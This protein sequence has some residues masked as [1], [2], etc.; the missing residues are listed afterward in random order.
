MRH[1]R[2]SRVLPVAA[3]AMIVSLGALAAGPAG[4]AVRTADAVALPP[5]AY[6]PQRLP[7]LQNRAR[8][9]CGP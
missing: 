6:L 3:G 5:T 2:M 1:L 8:G 7:S 4:A 9:R